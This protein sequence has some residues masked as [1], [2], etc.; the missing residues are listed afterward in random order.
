[1]MCVM[2][3]GN[4]TSDDYDNFTDVLLP[5]G[6]ADPQQTAGPLDQPGSAPPTTSRPPAATITERGG[7]TVSNA[8]SLPASVVVQ[9][10]FV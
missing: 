9:I 3:S 4:V 10:Q 6:T 8:A 1:M 2:P 7:A 5:T